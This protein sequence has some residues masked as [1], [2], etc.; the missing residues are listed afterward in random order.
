MSVAPRRGIAARSR[1]PRARSGRPPSQ[2]TCASNVVELPRVEARRVDRRS[3]PRRALSGSS[4]ASSRRSRGSGTCRARR[5]SRTAA[6]SPA[7]A[8]QPERIS[9][10][11]PRGTAVRARSS[12][13]CPLLGRRR[14]RHLPLA[15]LADVDAR[16]SDR[17]R[18]PRAQL[19][20]QRACPRRSG[21]GASMCVPRVLAWT[22]TPAHR[23]RAY[24]RT[25]RCHAPPRARRPTWTGGRRRA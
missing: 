17:R 11:A 10:A 20:H 19:G 3:R 1:R 14:C 16:R 13:R 7:L 2:P 9:T 4:T 21:R 5:R 25:S 15:A 6:P 23:S 22:S 24:A 12:G 18:T 8:S